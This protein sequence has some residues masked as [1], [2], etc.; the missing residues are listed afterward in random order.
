MSLQKALPALL[1]FCCTALAAYEIKTSSSAGED[2]IVKCG[3]T[4]TLKVQALK[5]GKAI[6]DEDLY[7]QIKQYA[8]GKGSE[9]IKA[10]IDTEYVWSVAMEQ[11]GRA[12]LVCTIKS[13]KERNAVIMVKNPRNSK[14]RIN[15]HGIGFFADPDKQR[16]VREEPADFDEFWNRKK[17]E[18]AKVPLKVLEKEAFTSKA[19]LAK[20]FEIYDM[21]LACAGPVPVSGIITIPRDK[22]RKY[23]A[24]VQYHG[25]GVRSANVNL[26][27]G[28][29][30]FN[31]NAHGLPNRQPKKFYS[32]ITENKQRNP[33]LQSAGKRFEM[34]Q[35]M[36]LRA[37]RALEYVRTLPEWNGKDL[38]VTG[39]SQGGVQTL[40][41]AALDKHVT[42][43][44][45]NIPAMVGSA[46]FTLRDKVE[47]AWPFPYYDDFYQK[48]DITG[49]AKKFDYIDGAFFMR[50]ITCEF[51]VAVGLYDKHAAHV[52]AAFNHRIA[53]KSSITG[54]PDMGH[55]SYN[56]MGNK[57]IA[58]I[59][60]Q[61]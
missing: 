55:Y 34:F 1:L 46:E 61:K 41:A 2:G 6:A 21:K 3:E 28:F 33:Y 13:K 5:D 45:P 20:E 14:H 39:G 47:A 43:A 54:I 57:A 27:P 15:R 50:R 10:P 30:T 51:H 59:G 32:D 16:I 18:L 60:A 24:M 26:Q 31:V 8:D 35:Y 19:A 7:L 58:A 25:A 9:I 52:F 48:K 56:P 44:V 22:S 53:K 40:A 38:I 37:L 49:I 4:V 11:P 17:D 29:I 36:F 12:Y 23:P 42:L